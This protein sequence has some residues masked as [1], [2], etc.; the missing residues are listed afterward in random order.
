MD[1]R[2]ST[3]RRYYYTISEVQALHVLAGSLISCA[4]AVLL[5]A[6]TTRCRFASVQA[7]LACAQ[8]YYNLALAALCL[9]LRQSTQ[10]EQT[11]PRRT[12]RSYRRHRDFRKDFRFSPEHIPRLI[13]AL[14]LPEKVTVG[15]AG[16][17][18]SITADEAISVLLFTLATNATLHRINQ[19]FG[20]K[21]G[22]ASATLRWVEQYIH[23]RWYKPL[24]VTDFRRWTPC[25]R[26]WAAAAH[27]KQGGRGYTGIVAFIDGTFIPICRP[28]PHLQRAF[29]S[30]YKKKHGVHFQGCLAPNGL[31]IDLSGPFPGRHSDKHMLNVS[32][33]CVRLRS[34]LSWAVDNENA[35]FTWPQGDMYLFADG[36]Y[37]R[38]L[39]LQT[40][41]VK[42]PGGELTAA[43]TRINRALASTRIANE[44][45]YG[46]IGALWPWVTVKANMKIQNE[47]VG[48][49]Y[50]IA[51]L[52]TNALTCLE[53]N[54]TSQYFGL[55]PPTLE[56]YF[57]EAPARATCPPA[58]Y[59]NVDKYDQ[60]DA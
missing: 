30:G 42:P 14:E 16:A 38:R 19:K 57:G 31:I 9:S 28:P 54:A 5:S 15:P 43:Q 6:A 56:T 40:M 52:L 18:Y 13:T 47:N 2:P 26:A 23:E 10:A 49:M 24:F 4:T 51:A 29:Y 58:W 25:F 35:P 12:W 55:T 37:N 3:Y 53:G 11:Y 1:E 45:I 7:L 32:E 36:G 50:T 33:I 59:E 27:G 17:R 60:V 21:R 46:R 41:Y 48:H 44:W 20:L 22:K 39:Q 34:A 8:E